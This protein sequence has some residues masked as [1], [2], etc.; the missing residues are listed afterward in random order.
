M[1][2]PLFFF[3]LFLLSCKADIPADVLPPAKMQPVLWDVLQADE[4]A[5]TYVSTD[6]SFAAL[7]K[8]AAYYQTIF[9]LH[10]TNEQTFKNSIRFYMNHP[11]LLKPILDSLQTM[12]DRMQKKDS[13]TKPSFPIPDS[14]R[15]KIRMH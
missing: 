2:Y 5:G 6:S 3:L 10:K 8:H 7:A 14:V 12:G 9:Q 15:K 1:R 11:A 13:T 4:I